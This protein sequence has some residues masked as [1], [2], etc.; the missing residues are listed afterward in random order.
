M[1]SRL[2]TCLTVGGVDYKIRTDYHCILDILFAFDDPEL[3]ENEKMYV[4]LVILYKTFYKIPK[5]HYEEAY[6]KAIQFI[7]HGM[8]SKDKSCLRIVDW[9]QDEALIFPALNKAAGFEIRAAGY[10]HWWTF[11][12]FYM[13]MPESIYSTIIRL[14]LKKS[15]HEK[16]E[17]WETKFWQSNKDICVLKPKL[18]VEEQRLKEK[19]NALFGG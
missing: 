15:K 8:N 9:E 2:P 16:F 11:L 4:C 7:E 14:R 1:N 6:Q 10:L 3:K 17:K 5:Q 19:A 18:T 13:E 12:G